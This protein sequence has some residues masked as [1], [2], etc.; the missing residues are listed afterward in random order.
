MD[1]ISALRN[2]EAALRDYETGALDLAGLE[3]RVG[4]ILRSYATE[5]EAED[6]SVYRATDGEAEGTI[7]AAASRAEARD[8]IEAQYDEAELEFE[9]DHLG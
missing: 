6:L 9:L 7:V 3:S 8:R 2:I 5:F 1:R 4:T